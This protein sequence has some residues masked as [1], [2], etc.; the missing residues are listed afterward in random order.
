MLQQA[1]IT[2]VGTGLVGLSLALDLLQQ[3][4]NITLIGQ[5][6]PELPN[7]ANRVVALNM[8]S[9][10]YLNALGAWQV[11]E[12]SSLTPYQKMKIWEKDSSGKLE[13]KASDVGTQDLGY[14]VV[15]SALEQ[16]LWQQINSYLAQNP[17]SQFT[18]Y[19]AK[20]TAYQNL[21]QRHYLSLDSG[22]QI[23]SVFVIAADG[24]N[25]FIRRALNIGVNRSEY[26]QTALT[27]VLE[28]PTE[29]DYT[30][31]QSF[32]QN[33]ILAYLPLEKPN[34]VS[35][36]WSLNNDVVDQV[37]AYEPEK[38]CQQVYACFANVLGV[39]KLVSKPSKFPLAKQ[40]A[41]KIYADNLVFVG[42]AAHL[43]HPLAGQGVNLGFAD[44]WQLSDL[45]R[46]YYRTN[47]GIEPIKIEAWARKRVARA[48]LTS[49]SMA[50]IKT[51]FSNN[52]GLLKAIRNTG[53]NLID[54]LNAPKQFLIKNALGYGEDPYSQASYNSALDVNK[55]QEKAD[56]SGIVELAQKLPVQDVVKKLDQLFKK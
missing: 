40:Y 10:E 14:I 35:I 21:Q 28:L 44:A 45:I 6:S 43:I 31:Y 24:G 2:I 19:D 29:H 11:I 15:N 5:A 55:I 9:K 23:V 27:C 39:P 48:T 56:L 47:R 34:Q 36:V 3:G 1:D 52:N 54:K 4:H 38:F 7:P 18:Y 41:Q 42:D 32:H 12:S 50:V 26:N 46:N 22:E 8:A 17:Q 16:A 49:E 20:V 53:L 13:F 30:C 51:V 33:G 37:L 25:S